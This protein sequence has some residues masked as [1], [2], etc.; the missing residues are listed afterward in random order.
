MNLSYEQK[1]TIW[2]TNQDTLRKLVGILGMLLPVLLYVFLWLDNGHH[3]PLP[4]I[5]HYY[6]TRVS[7][8]FIIVLSLLAVFLL[9]YKGE[10][11]MDFYISGIAG[12][13]AL[14]V[15]LFPTDNLANECSS[16]K[17]PYAVT[18]LK[19]SDFRMVLHFVAAAIFL[20]C[21]ACM[22]LFIF[23]KS[24][25]NIASRTPEKKLRN[26]IYRVCGVLIILAIIVI[27]A[28]ATKLIPNHIFFGY[29]LIFWM[30]VLAVESFGLAWM[31]KG[32]SFFVDKVPASD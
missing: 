22:S 9:I 3:Q 32:K 1:G 31:I 21:L 7:S 10:E 17:M 23:T 30:E 5:S 11:K 8:I 26:R 29:N 28:G 6:Y 13:S 25:F 19:K 4:S 18:I 16:V 12:L 15:V 20:L 2:L 27:V 14:V 24:N